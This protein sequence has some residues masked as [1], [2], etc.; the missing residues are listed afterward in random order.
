M[1]ALGKKDREGELGM[2]EWWCC[3]KFTPSHLT[4][5]SKEGIWCRCR[6]STLAARS[7]LGGID[8]GK[9]L[10]RLG[11]GHLAREFQCPRTKIV[12]GSRGKS[13]A[14]DD[15]SWPCKHLTLQGRAWP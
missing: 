8:L 4:G 11:G 1:N 12:I 13:R 2:L 3:C 10:H 9:K 5:K 14:P 15:T 6:D 7:T